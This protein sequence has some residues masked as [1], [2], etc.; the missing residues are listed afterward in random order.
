MHTPKSETF[1]YPKL[2]SIPGEEID[3]FDLLPKKW[4]LPLDYWQP[5]EESA[6]N[7]LNH[8]IDYQLINLK[9]TEITQVKVQPLIYQLIC[10]LEKLAL[11]PFG[12]SWK[13]YDL[14]KMHA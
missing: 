13:Q 14:I 10:I 1:H 8:F 7:K 4:T 5:G 11:G 9:K 6:L 3:S 2:L 12:A